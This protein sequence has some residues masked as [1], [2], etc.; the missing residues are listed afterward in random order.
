[1]PKLGIPEGKKLQQM[2]EAMEIVPESE[3][4]AKLSPHQRITRSIAGK[5]KWYEKVTPALTHANH[6]LACVRLSHL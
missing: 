5:T 1:M 4:G 3:R 2:A 6:C